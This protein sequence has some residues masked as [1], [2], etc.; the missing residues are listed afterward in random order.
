MK[1]FVCKIIGH[2][3]TSVSKNNLSHQAYQCTSCQQKFMAGGNGEM[4]KLNSHWE[5]NNMLFDRL[6]EKYVTQAP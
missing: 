5:E 1:K 2:R 3:L 6:L 4:V